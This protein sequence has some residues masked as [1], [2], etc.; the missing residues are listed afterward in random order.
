MSRLSFDTFFHT[1]TGNPPYD[2]QSRLAGNDPGKACRS[3]LVNIPTGLGKTVAVVLAWLWNRVQLQNPKW[4]RRLVYCLPMRTLA[5]FITGKVPSYWSKVT[6]HEIFE[7]PQRAFRTCAN[8]APVERDE[9]PHHADG[10]RFSVCR[11][12]QRPSSDACRHPI[13][14]GRFPSKLGGKPAARNESRR[15]TGRL[16]PGRIAFAIPSGNSSVCNRIASGCVN[17]IASVT[18]WTAI[19]TILP[20]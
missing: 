19:A 13:A 6:Q 16:G 8:A 20:R 5:A 12:P 17:P 18:G 15:R 2:Y 3:Q 4:P 10:S 1:V 14:G 7:F 9:F 11:S